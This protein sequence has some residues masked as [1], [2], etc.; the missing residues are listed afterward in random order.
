MLPGVPGCWLGAPAPT[1]G[2]RAGADSS[3]VTQRQDQPGQSR[4]INT[5]STGSSGWG[6]ARPRSEQQDGRQLD[7]HPP[8]FALPLQEPQTP[9]PPDTHSEARAQTGRQ[10]RACLVSRQVGSSQQL[11]EASSS[12]ATLGHQRI[13]HVE[14]EGHQ[15]CHGAQNKVP[16][17]ALIWGGGAAWRGAHPVLGPPGTPGRRPLGHRLV[18]GLQ[19]LPNPGS[20]QCAERE[21]GVTQCPRGPWPRHSHPR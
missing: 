18:R 16:E 15:G 8:A 20:L 3:A 9:L 10:R 2:P 1:G 4:F 13:E 12:P 19:L 11:P 21:V 14:H 17:A 5:F 6:Q 7:G